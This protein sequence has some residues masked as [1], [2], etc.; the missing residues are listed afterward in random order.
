MVRRRPQYG[1]AAQRHGGDEHHRTDPHQRSTL[2]S[3]EL[4][5]GRQPTNTTETSGGGGKGG[6]GPPQEGVESDPQRP[7]ETNR[8]EAA[9]KKRLAHRLAQATMAGVAGIGRGTARRA[10]APW[11]QRGE[12]RE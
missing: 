2:W 8:R 4:R 10:A 12:A 5:R 3:F 9:A 1:G 11:G 7:R 6:R